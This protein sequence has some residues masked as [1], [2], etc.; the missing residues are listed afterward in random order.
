MSYR[1]KLVSKI[2]ERFTPNDLAGTKPVFAFAEPKQI[3]VS[4]SNLEDGSHVRIMPGAP[5]SFNKLGRPLSDAL[6]ICVWV[7]TG[8]LK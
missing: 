1:Q 6:L 4:R 3:R 5:F 8:H 7:F 2:L